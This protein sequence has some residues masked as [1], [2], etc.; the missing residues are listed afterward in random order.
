MKKKFQRMFVL[1][2]GLL[3][4]KALDLRSYV[5]TVLCQ[6]KFSVENM[7]IIA[8][9]KVSPCCVLSLL[10]LQL[11]IDMWLEQTLLKLKIY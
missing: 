2:S 3:L 5:F 7:N 4:A 10:I 9:H 1:I 8:L 11:I 6:Y